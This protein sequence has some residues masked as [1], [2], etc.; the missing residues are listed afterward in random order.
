MISP[1]IQN[2]IDTLWESEI[3]PTLSKYIEIPNKSPA[4]DDDWE[5]HG[6]MDEAIQLLES[7]IPIFG[8]KNLTH[9]IVQLEGRTPLLLVDVAATDDT[10]GNILLYGHYDKQPEFVGWR[11]N[12]G[13]WKPVLENGRLYG[14]GGADDGYALFGCLAAISA[15]ETQ[16]LPHPRCLI[17]IE[18]CEESGSFDLPFYLEALKSDIGKPDLLICLDAECGNYDQLWLTTSLRGLISGTLTV[19]VLTEGVHSGG[20]GGIV[21]SSFRILR[22]LLSRIEDV[23]SGE[24]LPYV[25][26]AIP[27]WV[28]Q[29]SNNLVAAIGN[30]VLER[31]PW[32]GKTNPASEDLVQ[33]VTRN[34]WEASMA[35]TGLGGAPDPK[36]AGNTLRPFTSAKI[37]IRTAPL[38]DAKVAAEKLKHIL[39]NHPPYDASVSFDIDAAE[40][41]WCSPVNPAWL[42]EA[43]QTASQ[44]TFG[45]PMLKMGTGGTIP[46]MTMLGK[47]FPDCNFVVTGVLGP[48]SNAH[49]PN[50]FLDIETGKKVTGCIA[51]L[52][53]RAA[54]EL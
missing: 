52:V 8:I 36:Y 15:V 9:R 29:Q 37:A 25:N 6:Y 28:E 30:T 32:S 39:E 4:F 43:L 14:R 33:L 16:D 49:G 48:H 41:G 40:S 46:F 3:V 19:D 7:R 44:Q 20:A 47:T 18:G 42:E 53:A 17:L 11:E 34:S 5:A 50:E 26:C 2:H 1:Q 24:M 10:Q 23:H 13:P 22:E 35:V 27:A 38:V 45:Q 12:L 54:V 51:H 21:P 31:Y